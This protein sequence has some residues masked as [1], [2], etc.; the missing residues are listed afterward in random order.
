MHEVAAIILA[1]GVS[2]RMGADNK[3][4]LSVG[5]VAMIRRV[6]AQYRAAIDGPITVVTGH[7]ASHVKAALGQADVTCVFNS[8]YEDGQ[9]GSVAFGLGHAADAA[10]LLI[11]LGDQPLL[12]AEDIRALIAAHRN[13]DPGKVSVP[14]H[15]DKRGNPIVVPHVLR[16]QLT[17]NPER[18]GCMRFT[19]DNPDLVQRHLLPA[20]GFYTDIDTPQEYTALCQK[21]EFAL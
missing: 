3:L 19:R 1:A 13:A 20:A 11:G 16:S 9:Q 14:V 17:A 21:V 15:A 7:D 18:P 12:R 10:L 4:L 6:V 2:R 5:G 8:K